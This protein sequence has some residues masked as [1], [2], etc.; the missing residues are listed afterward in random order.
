MREKNA[1]NNENNSKVNYYIR[2]RHCI[3]IKKKFLQLSHYTVDLI[4]LSSH[5]YSSTYKML[6]DFQCNIVMTSNLKCKR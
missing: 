2:L 5:N 6:L 1:Q 3:H 4:E